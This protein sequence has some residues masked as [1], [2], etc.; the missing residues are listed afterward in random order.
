MAPRLPSIL[1]SSACLPADAARIQRSSGTTV[2]VKFG[3]VVGSDVDGCQAWMGIPFA[4]PPVGD[5]RFEAPQPWQS[6]YPEGRWDAQAARSACVQSDGQGDEDCLFLN[7]WRPQGLAAGAKLP[8][9]VWVHGGA[10]VTGAGSEEVYNGCLLAKSHDVIIA[11]VNYRLGMFGFGAFESGGGT[12]TNWGMQDQRE[13]LKWLQSEVGAFGGDP[14][15]VTVFGESAGGISIWHHLVAPQSRG[16]FRAAIIQSGFPGAKE[17]RP[18]LE[19][20]RDMGRRL[21]CTDAATLLA[22]MRSKTP[23]EITENDD[24]HNVFAPDIRFFQRWEPVEDGVELTAHPYKLLKEGKSHRV[25]VMSGTVNNEGTLFTYLL[26]LLRV[27]DNRY[28]QIVSQVWSNNPG[29]PSQELDADDLDR[30]FR[31]YPPTGSFLGDN[32]WSI[33][34]VAGDAMF[35]CA[36]RFGAQMHNQHSPTWTFNFNYRSEACPWGFP[37][38]GVPGVFHGM[39]IA[40]VFGYTGG[41]EAEQ[42]L[43]DISSRMQKYWTDFAKNLDPGAA[44]PRFTNSGKQELHFQAPDSVVDHYKDNYCKE[45]EQLLYSKLT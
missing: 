43:Q 30:V 23:Q 14:A 29:S 8:V 17:L 25:P 6:A 44:W 10:F 37:F 35:V 11:T 4:E 41:C 38:D 26:Y 5:L 15:K 7:I 28:R 34:E 20:T 45:W 13:A 32:R 2:P 21:N 39:E 18:A 19:Q 36:T 27:S 3:D 33:A 12:N 9:M 16:L 22:C 24:Q 1:L 31:V 40:A 42:E